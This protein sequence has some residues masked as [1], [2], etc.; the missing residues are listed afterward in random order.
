MTSA[1]AERLEL[2]DLRGIEAL[3]DDE[4]LGLQKQ[5]AAVRRAADRDMAVVAN[6]IGRRS[7]R[8]LGYA[9]LAQRSGD[10]TPERMI[11]RVS[12]LS[13]PEARAMLSAGEVLD[14]TGAW[15][16]PVAEGLASGDLTVGA[17]AGIRAGLGEP[18]ADVDADELARAA[19]RVA[20]DAVGSTPE[21]AT[22]LARVARDE[23]DEAGIEDRAE[24]MRQRRSLRITRLPDGMTRMTAVLDPE[25]AALVTDAIDRVTSPRRG[26]VRFVDPAERERVERIMGDARTTEQ[27][28]LDALVE[29]IRL[30]GF[31]DDGAVFGERG[32][33]V[34]VHVDVADLERGAG[35]VWIEGQDAILPVTVARRQLCTVGV[36]PVVLDERGEPLRL[37]RSQRTHTRAQRIAIAARDGGCLIPGCDR[38]PSWCEVHHPDEWGRGGRTDADNGVLLCRHHHMWAHNTGARIR[39]TAVPRPGVVFELVTPD[40][41]VTPLVSKCPLRKAG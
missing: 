33:E 9:G 14:G 18:S 36:L 32:P 22:K 23:L 31:V 21:Q 1:S 10:R 41:A 19:E 8:E 28:A 20:R 4:V 12:G 30:A 40:G 15:L 38:P 26:G 11:A 16:T 35:R 24:R 2:P 6:E 7:A 5:I 37:G 17:A 34:R 13:V 3:S 27:L 25:N 29:M 39:R